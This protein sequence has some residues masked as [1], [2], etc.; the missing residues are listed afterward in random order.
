MAT[1]FLNTRF[2]LAGCFGTFVAVSASKYAA[3]LGLKPSGG[4]TLLSSATLSKK[5]LRNEM[6]SLIGP[7]LVPPTAPTSYRPYLRPIGKLRYI[8][9][10][11]K[12]S[13]AR[14]PQSRPEMATSRPPPQYGR[15]VQ[16]SMVFEV[17]L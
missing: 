3:G 1:T 10:F 7:I 16:E 17:G 9:C 6:T 11:G 8:F 4:L 12:F 14:K 5:W 15:A 2:Y 13:P